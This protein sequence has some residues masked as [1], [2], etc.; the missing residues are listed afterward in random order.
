M[1]LFIEE[2]LQDLKDHHSDIS[3]LTFILPSKRARLFVLR[4]LSNLRIKTQFAPEILSIEEFIAEL[5]QLSALSN[6]ELLFRF[7]TVYLETDSIPLHDDFE[8]FMGW[9]QTLL[10]D[11]NELDRYLVEPEK[12]LNYLSAIKDLDHWSMQT[13]QTELM[14][15]YKA[16]WNSLYQLYD[17]LSLSLLNDQVGHQGLLYREAVGNLENY[18]QANRDKHHVFMGF[19]ALNKAESVIIQELLSNDLAE[20]YWDVDEYFINKKNHSAGHFIR[21]IRD[22][23]GYFRSHPFKWMHQHYSEKKDIHLIGASSSIIQA[24]YAGEI[25][26]ELRVKNPELNNTA[27]LLGDESILLPALSGLS[28]EIDGVNITMGYPLTHVPFT[29]LVDALFRM[30]LKSGP[31]HYFRDVIEILNHPMI[32]ELY[33]D[34]QTNIA[35]KIINTIRKENLTFLSLQDIIDLGSDKFQDLSQLLFNPWPDVLHAIDSIKRLIMEIKSA[36]KT[37][38]EENKLTLEF[39]FRYY[40]LLNNIETLNLSYHHL[41]SISAFYKLFKQLRRNETLDFQGE[42]LKGLQIMGI[43]ESRVIDFETVIISSVNEDILPAGQRFQSFFPIDVKREFGLPTYF[44]KDA[45]YAY[46]FFH[47]IQRA[48]KIYIL[49]GTETDA[50]NSGEI[51]RFIK[52]MQFENI[53]HLKEITLRPIIPPLNPEPGKILKSP[54]LLQLIKNKLAEGISPSSL[55]QYIRN[56]IDFYKN[57]L[58]GLDEAEE[59][60]EV[61]AAKTLGTVIHKSL[62]EIYTPFKGKFL[63]RAMLGDA[64]DKLPETVNRHFLKFFRKADLNKGKNLITREIAVQYIR[65]FLDSEINSISKGNRIKIIGIEQDVII[66]MNSEDL[67]CPVKLKGQIDRVDIFNG[68]PRVIDYK[69]GKVEGNEVELINWDELTSDYKSFGKSF[70]VLMYSYILHKRNEIQLPCEAGIISFKNLNSG[71]LTFAKKNKAGRGAIKDKEITASTLE[72]FENQ[73]I[74]LLNEITNPEIDLIEKPV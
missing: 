34:K 63:D 40:E 36:V 46:H 30:Q 26:D 71:F 15:D 45:V 73:L 59:V 38:Q 27:L 54:D 5:S 29:G 32:Y 61:I 56:P 28:P 17:R 37:G 57:T 4:A 22:K 58:L 19:N 6:S 42:P 48:K 20:I 14:A 51:S 8:T 69:T 50:L 1:G 11:F 41:N 64:N 49:Y 65:R 23:W 66:N 9:G 47:L 60:E 21:D 24:K 3:E 18:I 16:F 13:D 52:M 62:Q 35:Q 12:I 31:N 53:H 7:Y 55:L 67:P 10:N 70:Q 39:L 2:V 68:I 43:L 44:E 33:Q 25:L 72:A 74:K